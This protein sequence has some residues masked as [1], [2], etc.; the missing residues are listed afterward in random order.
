MTVGGWDYL[1]LTA[2]HARQARAY[3]D[4]LRVR[5]ALG[6]LPA[7]AESAGGAGS[8]RQAHR[9]RRR[10][11]GMSFRSAAARTGRARPRLGRTRRSGACIESAPHSH[12][13]RGWRLEAPARV[14][15]LRQ[16]LRPTARPIESA[17]SPTLF[18]RL[19]P[20]FLALPAGPA[21]RGQVVV[22][23]GD[24]LIRFD[25]RGVRFNRPGLTALGC[26]V[27]PEEASRHGVFR[28]GA[29]GCVARYF[30]KP[31]IQTQQVEGV[32]DAYG[33]A[34]LDMAVMQLDGATAARMISA[35][36]ADCGGKRDPDFAPEA[37]ERLLRYGL[38]LY[39]EICCA[40]GS[41]T[42]LEHYVRSALS[43]G[44]SWTPEML[45]QVFPALRAIPFHTEIV[46]ACLF[47]HFGSSRQLI[48]SGL[49]L[50]AEE[51][52]RPPSSTLLSVNSR[53]TAGG[54]VQGRNSWMEGCRVGSSLELQGENVIAGV[55]VSEP[56]SLPPRAC[57]E[58]LPG[59]DRAGSNVHF[60]RCYGVRDSFKD[61]WFCGRP[62]VSWLAAAGVSS[63]GVLDSPSSGLWGARICPAV[64]QAADFRRWLW[65]CEPETAGPE[66]RHAFC[67]ANRYSAAEIAE[68]TDQAAFH[69]RRASLWKELQRDVCDMQ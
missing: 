4:Q 2:S 24:A 30:Q 64:R 69:E 46:P 10:Y 57:L 34:P 26:Y 61:D 58:V 9:Q 17:A 49:A 45:G 38:D 50:V 16:N 37:R 20:G 68:L 41:E 18:D 43:S 19:A 63:E 39:R 54:G 25:A 59:C 27:T 47:L 48:E 21:G 33:R 12:P 8:G 55:D 11:A 36:G 28:L 65:M 22:A 40:L 3:E 15:A 7:G 42:T 32:L 60:V 67:S 29:D 62:L 13:P 56:L 23:A 14:R 51:A 35:F 66:K 53:I 1:A 5:T 52:G 44:S 6:L 31:S